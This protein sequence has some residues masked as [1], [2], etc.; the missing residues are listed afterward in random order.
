MKTCRKWKGV[1]SLD[2]NTNE[3]SPQTDEQLFETEWN[4]AAGGMLCNHTLLRINAVLDGQVGRLHHVVGDGREDMAVDEAKAKGVA[5]ILRVLTVEP[6][7]DR[8][9]VTSGDPVNAQAP[10]GFQGTP[11]F[12]LTLSVVVVAGQSGRSRQTGRQCQC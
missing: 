6:D 8:S 1:K 11:C 2:P 4:P 7:A 3:A 9:A 10:E 5:E 12:D